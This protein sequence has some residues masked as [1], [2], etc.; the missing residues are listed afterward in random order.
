MVRC[1]LLNT[2]LPS[3]LVGASRLIRDNHTFL[4]SRF[5][6]IP[7]IDDVRNGLLLCQP[8][9]QAFDQFLVSVLYDCRQDTYRL[10]VFDPTLRDQRLFD[11][12]DEHQRAVLLRGQ[13]APADWATMERPSFA[14]GTQFDL[15]T[16][17]GDVDGRPVSFTSPQR[18]YKRCLNWHAAVVR[19]KA[20]DQAWL[21]PDEFELE[22]FSAEGRTM[23]KEMQPVAFDYHHRPNSEIS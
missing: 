17:F 21:R 20:I 16:T 23:A 12:L 4:A 13:P 8:L 3:P 7:D 22:A 18:P 10:K 9:K 19:I 1:M 2:A 14:P 6:D 15:H 5:M 11:Q